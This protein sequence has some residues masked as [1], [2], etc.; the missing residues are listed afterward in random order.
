M[1]YY[2]NS[3][4]WN[5]RLKHNIEKYPVVNAIKLYDLK[6]F[7]LLIMIIPS[8]GFAFSP[9]QGVTVA[10]VLESQVIF[11]SS[12]VRYNNSSPWYVGAG[13][14]NGNYQLLLLSTDLFTE[15]TPP[16]AGTTLGVYKGGKTFEMP[17]SYDQ[18]CTEIADFS[19]DEFDGPPLALGTTY[20]AVISAT[21]GRAY[22]RGTWDGFT[23]TDPSIMVDYITSPPEISIGGGYIRLD[24]I[25]SS[26]NA[27]HCTEVNDYGRMAFDYVTNL[28]YICGQNGW[29]SK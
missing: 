12:Y 23:F 9:C 17:Q 6:I 28:L 15:Q 4:N 24:S 1:T 11:C 13:E 18:D 22:V 19:S 20:C 25:D 29:V 26:P 16:V 10:K 8:L 14:R 7:S 27:E 5:G 21:D 2:Q 3:V